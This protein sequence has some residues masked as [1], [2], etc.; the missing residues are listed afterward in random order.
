MGG[1]GSGRHGRRVTVE[2]CDSIKLDINE[3]MRGAPRPLAGTEEKPAIVG[4]VRCTVTRSGEAKP[5]A[6]IRLRME[7]TEEDGFADLLFDVDHVSRPVKQ[8]SQRVR[9]EATPCRFGGQRWWW[10][11]PATG[12]L[13]AKLYLPNGGV[14][15]LSRGRGAY[16]LAY[17]SQNASAID[18]SH[19]RL[20][21]L[22]RRLGEGYRYLPDFPPARPKGMRHRTYDRL[23]AEWD[24]ARERHDEIWLRGAQRLLGRLQRRGEC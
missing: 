16:D 24:A 20:R 3:L 13:C 1:Y 21:R 19:D 15:F 17:A 18:R 9:L 4:P 8:Q 23:V 7:L 12:R 11:C 22:H 6:V 14:R 5:W 2:R 10:V